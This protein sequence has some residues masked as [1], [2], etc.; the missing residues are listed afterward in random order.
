MRFLIALSALLALPLSL[1]VGLQIHA[2]SKSGAADRFS[3]TGAGIRG[4][5]PAAHAADPLPINV[6]RLTR[7]E[8]P[9]VPLSLVDVPID[10]DGAAGAELGIADNRT[11]GGFLGHEYLYENVTLTET[12]NL[13]ER[14]AD[15]VDEGN[16]LMLLDLEPEDLLAAADAAPDALMF[17]VRSSA[18][19]LRGGE[20]RSNLLHL[21]PSHAMLADALAQYLA[22]KRWSEVVLVTGRHEEDKLWSAALRRSTKRFGLK[23]VDEKDWDREPGARRTDSGHHTA[24]QEIPSFTRFADHDV[25]LVAD[26]G[27]EF[28]EYL[29]YRTEQPRPVA[30]TQ[31]LTPTSWHRAHEQWGATQ[32][33]RRFEAMAD[34]TMTPRDQASWLAMRALGEAVTQTGSADAAA[35]RDFLLSERLTLAG[36]K[37]VPLSFRSWNGQLRQPVL[38]VAPRML[39]SV[40]PQDGYLHETTELDTLGFDRPESGCERF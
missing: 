35:L 31:G 21:P 40:S 8:D 37:G 14:V 17:N 26:A 27:D 29:P 39:I 33:Q 16:R 15:L 19:S 7:E 30:G 28:G 20:C 12:E 4:W 32:I 5:M 1:D 6:V 34:R 23:I 24:Q 11:T 38:L 13:A 10:D 3:T 25:L 18:D 9:P 22:W 36:F 2:G